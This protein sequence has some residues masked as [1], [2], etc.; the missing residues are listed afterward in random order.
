MIVVSSLPSLS[1]PSLPLIPA[2]DKVFHFSEYAV[3]G[4]L[5]LRSAWAMGFPLSSK[6]FLR[7][8]AAGLLFA[9]LDELHQYPLPGRDASVFDFLADGAGMVFGIYLYT[10][11][12]RWSARLAI[13]QH[14]GG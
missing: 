10:V 5:G 1:A 3:L 7:V 2:Q 4:F 6:T 11:V 8:G 14:R 9:L 13:N 12:R